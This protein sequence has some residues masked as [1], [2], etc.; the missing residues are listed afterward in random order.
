MV[1]TRGANCQLQTHK[2]GEERDN[3]FPVFMLFIL[4][5]TNK[6]ELNFV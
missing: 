5:N 6:E 1:T 2:N 3:P 4:W